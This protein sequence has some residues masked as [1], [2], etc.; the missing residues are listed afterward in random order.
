LNEHG[1]LRALA[2]ALRSP[3]AARL[4]EFGQALSEHVRFE[5]QTLFPAAEQVVPEDLLEAAL[6]YSSRSAST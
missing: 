6:G 4:A 5:E 3:D 2:G 1:A